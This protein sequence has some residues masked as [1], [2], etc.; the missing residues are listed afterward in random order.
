M[1]ETNSVRPKLTVLSLEQIQQVHAYSLKIL[2]TVGVLV[3]SQK[4]RKLF[5]RAGGSTIIKDDR[6]YIPAELVDWAIQTAPSN[7]SI[8]DRNGALRFQLPGDARFGIGVTVLY[9]QDLETDAALPFCRKH[10]ADAV[11]LGNALPGYDVISTVGILQDVSPQIADLYAT[12]EM[13][14]NTVKPLIVLVSSDELFPAVLDLLENLHGDLAPKPAILPYVNPITPLVINNG[15]VDKMWCAIERGL[16]L[17]YSNY[18]MAGAS[19]PITPAGTLALL[20]A[21]LLAGL[22]LGQLI[23]EGTPMI[24]GILP[25]YFDMQGM[26]SF[27][28]TA[29][30]LLDVACAETMQYYRLP[31]VGT[32]GAGRGWGADLIAGGHQWFN[33]LI[34]CI[35][36][37]GL[38]PFIG[39][40]LDSKAFS[41]AVVVYANDIIEQVRR[42]TQGFRLDDASVSIDEI[43]QVGPGGNF[44]TSDLTYAHFRNAYHHSAVFEDLT[45]EKWQEKGSPRAEDVL[46]RYTKHLLEKSDPPEQHAQLIA[47]GEAFIQ[48]YLHRL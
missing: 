38:V 42:F 26:S 39:N 13:T 32:S 21:E 16:P 2:S 47:R 23:R 8:Y 27:Y 1:D 17:I 24:L 10:M 28:D 5:A 18:G 22:T 29:S 12:L 3:V 31:Q 11:R 48:D 37:V 6:V 33:C 30:Y 14:A 43:V 7:I 15:T 36:Q 25:A 40:N 35:S 41:P 44:L 45:L 46:R 19:T 4:A 34:S 20:N 9:Y